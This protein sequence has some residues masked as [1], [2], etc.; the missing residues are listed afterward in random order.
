MY[1][2]L[3]LELL[4][5]ASIVTVLCLWAPARNMFLH[6]V[7]SLGRISLVVV[8]I[9]PIVFLVS[10]GCTSPANQGLRRGLLVG[11]LTSMSALVAVPCTL[12]YLA[13]LAQLVVV[14]LVC[15]VAVFGILSLI[16]VI[17]KADLRFLGKFGISLAVMMLIWGFIAL[18]FGFQTGL[19]YSL[20]GAAAFTCLL[21]ADTSRIVKAAET[22][23]IEPLDASVSLYVDVV[24]LFIFTLRLISG[25]NN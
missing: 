24:G 1:W 15:T 5:S 7:L 19:L 20:L 23:Y 21:L 6:T 22:E 18:V 25:S 14:A 11:F 4:Y 10:M 2:W 13:G 17:T 8:T 16:L 9:I 12:Y 3:F